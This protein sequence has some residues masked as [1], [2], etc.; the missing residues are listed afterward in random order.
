MIKRL[1]HD[2]G[3][4][5]YWTSAWRNNYGRLFKEVAG[6]VESASGEV[7]EATLQMTN[8]SVPPSRQQGESGVTGVCTD[9]LLS[10]QRNSVWVIE[11]GNGGDEGRSGGF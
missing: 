3:L 10:Y 11:G 1:L 7:E 6:V 5:I 8:T 2:D 9:L 4:K